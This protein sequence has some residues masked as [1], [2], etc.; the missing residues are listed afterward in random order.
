MV[1]LSFFSLDHQDYVFAID[2]YHFNLDCSC[3]FAHL[4][5]FNAELALLFI[6]CIGYLF[7]S[8]NVL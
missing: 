3:F 2:A 6:L 8:S 7:F 5:A 4:I 1:T